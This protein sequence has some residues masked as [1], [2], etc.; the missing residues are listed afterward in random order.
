[1]IE[2][3]KGVKALADFFFRADT[4]ITQAYIFLLNWCQDNRQM[5]EGTCA[6]DNLLIPEIMVST[7][8]RLHLFLKLRVTADYPNKAC[9]Q[10]LHF[11]MITFAL[12]LNHFNY[13]FQPPIKQIKR[14]P[15]NG[16]DG[17]SQKKLKG[18]NND[19]NARVTNNDTV[20]E[21]KLRAESY[22]TFLWTR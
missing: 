13:Y 17:S 9:L 12:E 8:E 4:T 7:Y 5:L 11:S 10:Y 21:I 6:M 1:M 16:E 15:S 20:E 22:E 3:F 14:S 2:I 18:N 19:G